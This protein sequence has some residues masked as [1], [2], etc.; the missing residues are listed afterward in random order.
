M[1]GEKRVG[2]NKKVAHKCTHKKKTQY[3]YLFTSI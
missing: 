1:R 2:K 3:E